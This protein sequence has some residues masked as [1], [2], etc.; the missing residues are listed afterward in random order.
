MEIR[1]LT[2]KEIDILSARS[3]GLTNEEAAASLKINKRTAEAHMDRIRLK[4]G[5][6]NGMHAVYIAMKE[7]IIK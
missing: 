1:A 5:A 6:K 4:L 2:K 3:I 7:K